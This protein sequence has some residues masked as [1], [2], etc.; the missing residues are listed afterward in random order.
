M[1]KLQVI[2]LTNKV[3]ARWLLI[4]NILER[5]RNCSSQDLSKKANLSSRTI[6]KDIKD[7]RE[8]F[9]NTINLS[10]NNV[11]YIFTRNSTS[12]IKN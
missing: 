7:I 9:G 10:T 5:E 6:I 1:E 3:T 2:F 11:G 8:H 12:N 4:L